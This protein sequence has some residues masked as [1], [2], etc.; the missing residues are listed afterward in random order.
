MFIPA[1]SRY[2]TTKV[3]FLFIIRTNM[4]IL[5]IKVALVDYGLSTLQG[6]ARNFVEFGHFLC[7]WRCSPTFFFDYPS[8]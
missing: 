1:S 7:H 8:F 5:A 3:R 4:T 2:Y 6:A